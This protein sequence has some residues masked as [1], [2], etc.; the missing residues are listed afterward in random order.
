MLIP[1]YTYHLLAS[2][3]KPG[4]GAVWQMNLND[5]FGILISDYSKDGFEVVA[6]K[7]GTTS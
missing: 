3:G 4:K 2:F 5:L 7:D 1:E 6:A